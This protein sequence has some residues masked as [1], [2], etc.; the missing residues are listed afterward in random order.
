MIEK[1]FK[2]PKVG[3][4]LP[5]DIPSDFFDRLPEKTLQ[6]AKQR[7]DKRRKS[8]RLVR[9]I[10]TFSAAAVVLLLVAVVPPRHEQNPMRAEKVEDVLQ[11][12]T[13]DDLT[14]MTVVYGADLLEEEM[15]DNTH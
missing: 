2:L 8:K 4:E 10:V 13:D 14:N 5:N 15:T 7:G 9:N 12:L 1:E 3:K 6:M 11:D